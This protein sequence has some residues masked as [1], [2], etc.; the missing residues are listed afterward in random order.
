MKIFG[1]L[2]SSE[3]RK[4]T[5]IVANKEGTISIYLEPDYMNR[6]SDNEQKDVVELFLGRVRTI[7]HMKTWM[8][9]LSRTY[10]DIDIIFKKIEYARVSQRRLGFSSDSLFITRQRR[11][12]QIERMNRIFKKKTWKSQ[13]EE[14]MFN[15]LMKLKGIQLSE[16]VK[17][18][19][20]L[21]DM[22]R[23]EKARLDKRDQMLR[24]KNDLFR[25]GKNALLG[26]IG[27]P[28]TIFVPG[29]STNNEAFLYYLED[30]DLLE[31]NT[32]RY[33]EKNQ[34]V[35]NLTQKENVERRLSSTFY[36]D[37][38]DVNSDIVRDSSL[39][40]SCESLAFTDEY[41]VANIRDLFKNDE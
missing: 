4:N 38:L 20:P 18:R 22:A 21:E 27:R 32:L 24:K 34:F 14:D 16:L 17:Y 19:M 6:F 30:Y 11:M 28:E 15:T 40:V 41:K 35:S 29:F 1:S 9:K 2:S 33:V 7:K 36:S 12:T 37:V 39:F 8:E 23:T 5:F 10:E 3:C 31:E 26:T 25:K 13:G